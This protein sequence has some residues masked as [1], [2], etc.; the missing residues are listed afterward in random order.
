VDDVASNGIDG[1]ATA[2]GYKPAVRAG[3]FTVAVAWG[4][5]H[6]ILA[7]AADRAQARASAA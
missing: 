1:P 5:Q 4:K 3:M 7:A 2:I 6:V